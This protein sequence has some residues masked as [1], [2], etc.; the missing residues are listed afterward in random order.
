MGVQR[1]DHERRLGA[2]GIGTPRGLRYGM[3]SREERYLETKFGEGYR[4]CKAS[5]RRRR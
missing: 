5:V 3:I 4:R 2:V 1:R